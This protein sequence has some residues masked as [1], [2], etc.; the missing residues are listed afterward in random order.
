MSVPVIQSLIQNQGQLIQVFK[1]LTFEGQGTQLLPPGF[2]QV[3]PTSIFGNELQL[4]LRPGC[5]RQFHLSTGVNDHII[6]N[7]QPTIRRKL[8]DHL[9]YQLNMTG[10]IS[11]RADQNACLPSRGFE[12]TMHPQL[13]TP[14]VVWLKGSS[15]RSRLPFF[16]WIGFDRDW[17]HFINA[18]NTRTRR[19]S[20]VGCDD[21]PLSSA[22]SG[23]DFSALWNQLCWRFHSNP[24]ASNHSQIVESDKWVWLRSS[25]ARCSRS[26]VHSSKG[27]PNP[28]GFWIANAIKAL[29]TSGL[30]MGF[31]PGRGW[32]S[33]PFSPSLL[34]HRTHSAPIGLLLKPALNPASVANRFGSSNM[35]A[36]IQARCTN[37]IGSLR[38]PANRLISVISSVVNVRSFTGVRIRSSQGLSLR[39]L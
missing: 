12:R 19:R 29:L 18:N 1:A 30:W 33:R 20:Y 5:Q 8:T 13:S 3:Q 31:F 22:N 27:Y 6:F 2:N 15:V 37:R 17:P 14:T 35:A 26:N 28:L 38:E 25:R 32:S 10:T 23:S 24:S 11:S 7:D 16:S 9:F 4:N 21:A 39:V 36:I 34:K